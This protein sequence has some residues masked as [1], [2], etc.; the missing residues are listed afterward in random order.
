MR[1]FRVN[2][3]DGEPLETEEMRPAWF[4]P[5]ALPYDTMW[6]DD[7]VWMPRFLNGERIHG[8]FQF[9]ANNQHVAYE[10]EPATVDVH[11]HHP[12]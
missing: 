5:D 8:W 1:L 9:N 10:L 3:F 11:R 6:S 4:T 2:Q 12:A 7:R